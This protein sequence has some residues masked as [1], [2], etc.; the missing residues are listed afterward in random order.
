MEF[1]V[2]FVIRFKAEKLRSTYADVD[3]IWLKLKTEIIS[4]ASTFS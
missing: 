1:L 3:G 4:E 2:K